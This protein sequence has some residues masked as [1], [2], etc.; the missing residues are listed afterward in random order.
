MTIRPSKFVGRSEPAGGPPARA[1]LGSGAAFPSAEPP[2]APKAEMPDRGT[3]FTSVIRHL[4]LRGW[5]NWIHANHSDASLSVRTKEGAVGHIWCIGGT[6]VDAEWGGLPAELALEQLLLLASGS[7]TIDFDPVERARRIS[8][9]AHEVPGAAP[10][11]RRITRIGYTAGVFVLAALAVAA[12]SFGRS[13]ASDEL[14]YA[15]R[16]PEPTR[17]EEA[18][19]RLLPPAPVQA[20]PQPPPAAAA[21]TG[22]DLP[23][24]SFAQIEVD[25]P[26]ADIL[27]DEELVGTGRISQGPI[28]DGRMHELRFVAAG[29]EARSLFF[30]DTP[31]T[32][33]VILAR[34]SDADSEVSEPRVERPAP[35]RRSPPALQARPALSSPPAPSPQQ[36]QKSPQVQVI[37]VDAPRV[38]IVE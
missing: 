26:Y 11:A 32:G 2:P 23:L 19:S 38:Q 29:H 24:I 36:A 14:A 34:I 12:F 18:A 5:L 6:V 37:E 21:P 28:R 33:R 25:P 30:R 15:A 8:N 1:E 13:R 20:P 3:G 35:R 31:P 22:F 4:S 9:F 17:V 10:E 7:V 27:L 16:A